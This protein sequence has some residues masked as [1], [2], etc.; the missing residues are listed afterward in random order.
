MSIKQR[1]PLQTLRARKGEVTHSSRCRPNNR[2]SSPRR[3]FGERTTTMPIYYA[4][5]LTDC[6]LVYG[7]LPRF[8]TKKA[9]RPKASR[10]KISYFRSQSGICLACS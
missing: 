10:K 3:H 4:S 2:R 6:T 5:L 1:S 7:P 8:D 9:E